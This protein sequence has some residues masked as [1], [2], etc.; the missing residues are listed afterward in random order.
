[1]LATSGLHPPRPPYS[2]LPSRQFGAHISD[3]PTGH[4]HVTYSDP[5]PEGRIEI[6]EDVFGQLRRVG[7]HQV[8]GWDDDVGVDVMPHFPRVSSNRHGRYAGT[9]SRTTSSGCTSFPATAAAAAT[10][11]L[12]RYT[13]L[14]RCPIRPTKLRLLVE[15]HTSPSAR[16]PICPPIHGPQEDVRMAAPG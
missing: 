14:P 16:T 6:F 5:L 7:R 13:L 15:T 4:E 9:V 8:P 1:M 11:A 10:A 2:L 12:L 3:N